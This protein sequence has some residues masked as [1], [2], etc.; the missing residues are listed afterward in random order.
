MIGYQKPFRSWGRSLINDKKVAPFVIKYGSNM[1]QFMGGDYICTFDGK[2]T[3]GFYDK[4]DKAMEYNLISKRN[5]AM[6]L[7]ELRCKA[8]IQDY[9]ERIIDKR[10][11]TVK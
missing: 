9:M 4:N 3:I 8:F 2:K 1:Y 11:T 6:D 7:L 10:L 5:A